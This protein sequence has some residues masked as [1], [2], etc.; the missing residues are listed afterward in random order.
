MKN[1]S[2]LIKLIKENGIYTLLFI[3]LLFYIIITIVTNNNLS[4]SLEINLNKTSYIC[5]LITILTGILYYIVFCIYKNLKIEKKF[6]LIIIP[7]GLIFLFSFPIG[8]IPD[9]RAHFMRSYEISTG[10]I[11]SDLNDSGVGGRLLPKTLN[12]IIFSNGTDNYNSWINR[13]KSATITEEKSFI[14]FSNTALYNFICYMPQSIGI[15]IANIFTNSPLIMAYVGRLF[16]FMLFVFIMYN[17][18]K[19]LP[20]KKNYLF[21]ISILPITIQEAVSLSPDALTISISL[22]FISYILYLKKDN[23]K[24]IK[25]NYIILVV[26]AV[27]LTFC[28]IVYLPLCILLLVLPKN[29]FKSAKEKNLFLICILLTV[30]I[31]NLIWL[32]YASRYLIEFNEN[33]NSKEQIKFILTHPIKYIMIIVNT[34][35]KYGDTYA[36]NLM[37]GLG[38][39]LNVS[40]SYVFQYIILIILGIN[41][42]IS[43]KEEHIDI[44]TRSIFIIVF[45]TV[46]ALIFSSLYVQWTALKNGVVIGVQ[47]RYL[48]PIILLIPLILNN[49]KY[50]YTE[51]PISRY[52]LI[53]MVFYGINTITSVILHYQ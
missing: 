6:L 35:N 13:A 30:I 1:D 37:G 39:L 25:R 46:L 12:D 20:Y 51:D 45:L 11:V 48:L 47:G 16:N 29:K 44:Y 17:A 3:T 14:H 41:T 26:T 38:S 4:N 27:V 31:L 21:L 9:E 50:I 36:L 33:V 42:V 32:I 10:H 28:K 53:F 40:C 19:Y 18:I 43:N 23:N 24:L 34:I 52:L 15:F 5:I 2:K 7:I 8:T 49:K 22:F